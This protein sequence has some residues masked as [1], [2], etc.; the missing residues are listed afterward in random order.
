MQH[1]RV[2]PYNQPFFQLIQFRYPQK[3]NKWDLQNLGYWKLCPHL[4]GQANCFDLKSTRNRSNS[5]KGNIFDRGVQK[6]LF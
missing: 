5:K 1:L 6:R 2:F 4:K 3:Q